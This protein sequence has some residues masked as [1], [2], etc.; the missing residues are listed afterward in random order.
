MTPLANSKR[1]GALRRHIAGTKRDFNIL[2]LDDKFVGEKALQIFAIYRF[3]GAWTLRKL[4]QEALSQSDPALGVSESPAHNRSPPQ[5]ARCKPLLAQRESNGI[6]TQVICSVPFAK[7]TVSDDPQRSDRCGDI[8][9][10]EGRDTGSAG[11]EHVVLGRKCVLP[12]AKEERHVGEGGD[13]VAVEGVGSV[14][15]LGCADPI[16]YQSAR[17]RSTKQGLTLC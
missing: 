4:Y 14:P 3:S 6:A 9:S 2:N 1:M 5:T 8:H 17:I 13:G 16:G 10:S 15:R 12:A 7:E 11:V